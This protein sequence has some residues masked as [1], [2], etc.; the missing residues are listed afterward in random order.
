MKAI[1]FNP[2]S[3]PSTLPSFGNTPMSQ[4]PFTL[5]MA[6]DTP[7]TGMEQGGTVEMARRRRR[8]RR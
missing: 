2:A 7:F 5:S 8:R 1:V 3:A 4:N 6:Q